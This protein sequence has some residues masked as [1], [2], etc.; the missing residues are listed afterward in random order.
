MGVNNSQADTDKGRGM[1]S[2]VVSPA[3]QFW[4]RSQVEAVE[5]LQFKL[6]GRDRQILRGHIPTVSIAACR[7][8]YQG[9]HP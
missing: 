1:I 4:L 7:A 8:I 5:T 3:V 6:R 9:L 2:T